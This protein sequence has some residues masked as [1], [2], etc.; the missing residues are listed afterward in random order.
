MYTYIYT[1]MYISIYIYLKSH[2]VFFQRNLGCF[3]FPKG[4]PT[5]ISPHVP[6]AAHMTL[7]RPEYEA[8][9]ELH[10]LAGAIRGGIRMAGLFFLEVCV[11]WVVPLPSNSHHQDFY[12]FSRGSL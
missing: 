9:T 1:H 4:F 3:S 10:A 2:D 8:A 6:S 12:I 5:V 11:F 7:H